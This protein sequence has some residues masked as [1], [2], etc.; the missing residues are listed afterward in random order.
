M[1]GRDGNGRFK[2]GEWKGG[3]GRSKDR[4]LSELMGIDPAEARMSETE[5]R[6]RFR[7][8]NEL[9]G[10]FGVLDSQEGFPDLVLKTATGGCVR[11]EVEVNSSNFVAH[12]HDTNGCDLII[13]WK[14]NWPECPLPVLVIA[15]EW[16]N[17]LQLRRVREFVV[18][19]PVEIPIKKSV[20]QAQMRLA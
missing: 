6:E 10:W 16:M 18:G 7:I 17:Y 13:C 1:E 2:K 20:Q 5:T 3:P 12:G 11:A 15:P 4:S 19:R 9:Y 14:H 8:L